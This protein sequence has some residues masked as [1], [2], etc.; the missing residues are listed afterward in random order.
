MVSKNLTEHVYSKPVWPEGLAQATLKLLS[1]GFFVVNRSGEIE[2]DGRAISQQECDFLT[3]THNRLSTPGAKERVAL[4]EALRAATGEEKQAV[5]LS[6]ADGRDQLKM[7]LIAPFDHGPE[8]RALVLFETNG[9]DHFALR[10]H[11]FRAHSITRSEALV[12]HEVLNGRS[13][14]EAS[15]S[16]GLSLETVRSYLKQVFYKTGT[17]RQSELISLYYSWTLPVGKSIA[18][19]EMR[20]RN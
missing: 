15:V 12:A 7:V 11:F 9:T 10:E 1:I 14:S 3:V 20:R 19:A 18:L 13:P 17:H 4:T 5:I 6:I 8:G 2:I 16:T